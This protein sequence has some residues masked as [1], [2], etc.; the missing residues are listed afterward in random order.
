MQDSLRLLL[1]GI[2]IDKFCIGSDFLGVVYREFYRV[3]WVYSFRMFAL[4]SCEVS[5]T[6]NVA[7]CIKIRRSV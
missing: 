3:Y 7:C 6:G 4:F 5:V 1:D 2:E